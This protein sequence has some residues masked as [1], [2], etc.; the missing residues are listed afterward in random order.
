MTLTWKALPSMALSSMALSSKALSSKALP[1]N[2]PL[3]QRHADR[4]FQAHGMALRLRPEV[5]HA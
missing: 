4:A 2:M 1:S 3:F 5:A